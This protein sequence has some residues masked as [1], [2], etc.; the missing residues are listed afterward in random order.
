MARSLNFLREAKYLDTDVRS[1]DF[2]TLLQIR[3]KKKSQ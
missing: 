1:P 3:G 2:E